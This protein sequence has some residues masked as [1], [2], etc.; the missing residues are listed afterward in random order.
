MIFNTAEFPAELLSCDISDGHEPLFIKDITIHKKQME[1]NSPFEASFGRFDKLTKLFPVITFK[2]AK[3][4]IITGAGECPPL[5]APWYDGE[6]DGTVSVALDF[7]ISSLMANKGEIK[8]AASFIK[9]YSWIVGHNIAKIGVE[10]AYWDAV[11]KFQNVPVWKLWGGKRGFV[12]SGVSIGL[13]E[14][15][16]IMMKKVCIAVEQMKVKRVKIKIKPG[17]DIRYVEAIRSI[18]PELCLQVDANAS[19]DLFNDEHINALKELDQFNL[20]MIEQPGRNNDILDHARRLTSFKTSICLDESIIDASDARKAIE[21]WKLYSS[22]S[23]LIINI[24]PPR[25]GSFLEAIRI[26]RLCRHYGISTWCG[27]MLESALGKT[28]NVHFSSRE[29]VNL[30]GDHVSFGPYFKEDISESPFYK[31]GIIEVPEKAGWGNGELKF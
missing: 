26:A 2:D 4:S 3:G 27:G 24:K 16:D 1:L 9:R 29:E 28:S 17:K 18:Y 5:P 31:D 22:L 15:P 20:T 6:C 30:P 25:V 21:C 14:T 13:E 11:G 12:E 23:K 8:D 10:A 7:V 19:Y